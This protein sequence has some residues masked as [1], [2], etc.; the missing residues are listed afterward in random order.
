MGYTFLNGNYKNI[1]TV[2]VVFFFFFKDINIPQV[3]S[4]VD[5]CKLSFSPL[6]PPASFS[7]IAFVLNLLK[8]LVCRG[9]VYKCNLRFGFILT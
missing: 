2:S 1:N 8:V 4:I 9:K 6:C 7:R 5:K 3:Y